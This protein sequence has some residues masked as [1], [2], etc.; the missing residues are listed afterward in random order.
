MS[1]YYKRSEARHV[2]VGDV[3]F[4][5]RRWRRVEDVLA[6]GRG[7]RRGTVAFL[8]AGDRA[9]TFDAGAVV[10]VRTSTIN[11]SGR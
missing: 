10:R 11:G 4:L 2:E 1:A 8:T 6:G 9:F 7:P 3:V 5:S